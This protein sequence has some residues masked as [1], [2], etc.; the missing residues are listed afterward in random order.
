MVAQSVKNLLIMKETACSKGDPG[1]IPGSGRSH[2]EE[3]GNPFQYFCLENLMDIWGW[4]ATVHGVTR[5][6]HDLTTKPRPPP[7]PV[8]SSS[9]GGAVQQQL[10][11]LMFTYPRT[12]A[13]PRHFC[14]RM[15]HTRGAAMML[16]WI[17]LN[18]PQFLYH[19]SSDL[20][21]ASLCCFRNN[22]G[23]WQGQGHSV[24]LEQALR[25]CV[26]VP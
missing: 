14:P 24:E 22:T 12:A 20:V 10:T 7:P 8:L 18:P 13:P 16:R 26:W 6:R 21:K 1:S 2:G 25:L 4:W 19:I 15:K 17:K 23:L 11:L 5:V 3:N 9:P